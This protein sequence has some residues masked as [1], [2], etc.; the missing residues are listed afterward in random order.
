MNIIDDKN[1]NISPSKSINY[2]NKIDRLL[3]EE[4]LKCPSCKILYDSELHLPFVVKCGHSFCKQCII[5]NVNNKCPLDNFINAFE[6]YIKNIQLEIILNKFIYNYNNKNLKTQKQII[7]VKPDIKRN[8]NIFDDKETE[9]NINHLNNDAPINIRGKSNNQKEENND[10]NNLNQNSPIYN[11]H[12]FKTKNNIK[13][14]INN[15][16]N[17][18]NNKNENP[19]KFENNLDKINNNIKINEFKINENIIENKIDRTEINFKFEDE[20]I[21]NMFINESIETIPLYEEKSNTN[22]SIKE[23]FDE[24]LTKKEIY[25]KRIVININNNNLYN[26]EENKNNIFDTN[27][28]NKSPYNKNIILKDN[29]FDNNSNN[30]N[31]HFFC[32]TKKK[33][34]EEFGLT[35]PKVNIHSSKLNLGILDKEL[36][37]SEK[38]QMTEY[39][40]RIE[41]KIKYYKTLQN[42]N[43][44]NINKNNGN[45]NKNS[46]MNNI[47]NNKSKSVFEYIQS[48]KNKNLTINNNIFDDKNKTESPKNNILITNYYNN[49]R[50]DNLNKINND[51]NYS[52]KIMKNNNSLGEFRTNRKYI[53]VRASS[54]MSKKKIT[55][56]RN[57]TNSDCDEENT[58]KKKMKKKNE[59]INQIRVIQKNYDNFNT[60]SVKKNKSNNDKNINLSSLN[61]QKKIT[62][63]QNNSE[64]INNSVL[65]LEKNIKEKKNPIGLKKFENRNLSQNN[66]FCNINN[67]NIMAT[68]EKCKNNSN[69]KN[70]D[71]SK[72]NF[73]NNE[74]INK[75]INLSPSNIFQDSYNYNNK[76]ENFKDII[77]NNRIINSINSLINLNNLNNEQNNNDI[78]NNIIEKKN[79]DINNNLKKEELIKE[80]SQSSNKNKSI[81]VNSKIY[82]TQ[83]MNL[84]NKNNNNK[85]D[86]K[87][88]SSTK[89]NLISKNDIINKLKK[90][91][92][93]LPLGL[94]YKK[95]YNNFFEK[96]LENP[97]LDEI[98]SKNNNINIISLKLLGKDLLFIGQFEPN[99]IIPKKGLLI[100]INGE[101]Y[102]GD[103]M[104]GKKDGKG[105]LIYQ[106]GTQYIGEFKN[107]MHSGYGQLTQIDGEIYKGEWKDGKMNGKGTRFHTN[108]DKYIG[109]Y[110]D[111]I[112]NGYGTYIF[113]NGDLY[114]GNWINGKANGLGIFKY[115]N[116]NIYKGEFKDN[117]IFGKG[118]LILKNGDI[119]NGI[120]SNGLISGKGSMVNN[121]GE[122]YSGYFL[123]GKKNGLGILTN[124]K[125]KIIQQGYWK[126]NKF[127]GNKD[128]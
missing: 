108:G 97:I 83:N 10:N 88:I 90:E 109:N 55:I 34:Y 49:I 25:K 20:K 61:N 124:K 31:D 39:N 100:K 93:L 54:K 128:Y 59:K 43:I 51:T 84:R 125:G 6:T 63:P 94:E 24:L 120:F 117:L 7:Y 19:K 11:R 14:N 27:Y 115:K 23:D 42:L 62:F 50:I 22:L 86:K 107:D 8:N 4:H 16:E 41:K 57:N 2:N 44:T 9:N 65:S 77:K 69:T 118:K 126:M 79:N 76:K 110:V 64:S 113:S 111:N 122:K 104:N 81:I 87:I 66:L 96:S 95:I 114:E 75:S 53:K 5:N 92:D 105:K 112:R 119:Y 46:N 47:I 40:N 28:Y 74:I 73:I 67:L 121:K 98:I 52:N 3:L 70:S 48:N 26:N 85:K 12:T 36:L 35:I 38:R 13:K 82:V 101:Y 72:A 15:E 1:I 21:S 80:R 17:N 127:F 58:S 29:I 78:N 68:P 71:K 123:N 89:N 30:L 32:E 102:E 60:N 116:G 99:L 106:N 18:I 56:I 103:F 45:I 37:K 91:Y 33:I